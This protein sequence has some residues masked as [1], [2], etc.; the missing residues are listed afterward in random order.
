MKAS[1]RC[2]FYI[3]DP[4]YFLFSFVLF[5]LHVYMLFLSFTFTSGILF[6]SLFSQVSFHLL[7]R[8]ALVTMGAVSHEAV[9]ESIKHLSYKKMFI[10]YSFSCTQEM[11][12][13]VVIRLNS[14]RASETQ[15]NLLCDG[16]GTSRQT[17]N[18]V[19]HRTASLAFWIPGATGQTY[20]TPPV[21]DYEPHSAPSFA[22]P[23]TRSRRQRGR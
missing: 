3:N 8:W 13:M 17:S 12:T 18:K 19:P 22:F 21:I 5:Y 16:K 7:L 11:T 15:T 23:H 1:R 9:D 2:F 14:T 20:L 4:F 6:Y 10:F